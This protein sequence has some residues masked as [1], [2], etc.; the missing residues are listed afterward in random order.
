[1]LLMPTRDHLVHPLNH[2]GFT[3]EAPLPAGGFGA[4]AARAGVGKTAFLV[5]IALGFMLEGKSVLHISLNDPV[6]KVD[7]WYREVFRRMAET[8]QSLPAGQLTEAMLA[9]RFIM[10]FRMEGFS[11]P[12]LSE[13]LNNLTEQDIFHPEVVIIDGLEFAEATLEMLS[14][15]KAFAEAKSLNVWFTVTSHRHEAPGPGGI[16]AP[17]VPVAD[18]FD[19][20]IALQPEGKAIYV[21]TLKGSTEPA[22]EKQA[23]ILDPSSM[24]LTEA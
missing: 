15:I 21:R 13:R 20:V 18:L 17:L 3:T 11:M 16:P 4:V 1:M 23:L 12:V 9:N 2:L 6:K 5:Q 19:I 8:D 7:L 24:L 10:T 14:L 22:D